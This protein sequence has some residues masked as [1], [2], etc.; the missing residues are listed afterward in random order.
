M[1]LRDA[2]TASLSKILCVVIADIVSSSSLEEAIVPNEEERGMKERRLDHLSQN[3]SL[4]TRYRRAVEELCKEWINRLIKK[5]KE[6]PKRITEGS[7]TDSDCPYHSKSRRP[8][9]KCAG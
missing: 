4:L 3:E 5:V 6:V 1:R 8:R 7:S 9:L 2:K